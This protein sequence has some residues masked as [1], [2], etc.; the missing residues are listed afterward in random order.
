MTNVYSPSVDDPALDDPMEEIRRYETRFARPRS[1]ARATR[2]NAGKASVYGLPPLAQWNRERG[3]ALGYA[4]RMA[5][6][7][8]RDGDLQGI[9]PGLMPL[10]R[11]INA[12]HN[13]TEQLWDQLEPYLVPADEEMDEQPEDDD[14]DEYDVPIDAFDDTLVNADDIEPPTW[15]RI[16]GENSRWL[17]DKDVPA[18]LL[19][20]APAVNGCAWRAMAAAG[21]PQTY[22]RR[23][24]PAEWEGTTLGNM[25]AFLDSIRRGYQFFDALGRKVIEQR[26]DGKIHVRFAMWSN[27]VAAF[28]ARA[29]KPL[30]LIEEDSSPATRDAIKWLCEKLPYRGANSMEVAALWEGCGIRAPRFGGN[31]T[32][33]FGLDMVGSYPTILSDPRNVF[34]AAEGCEVIRET[35]MRCTAEELQDAVF[36]YLRA[37]EMPQE[38]R[39]L[40]ANGCSRY[41]FFWVWADAFKRIHADLEVEVAAYFEP[42]IQKM[43]APVSW[44]E[45]AARVNPAAFLVEAGEVKRRAEA[46]PPKQPITEMN[47]EAVAKLALKI[48][49]T[50]YSGFLQKESGERTLCTTTPM[51]EDEQHYHESAARTELDYTPIFGSTE[52]AAL[53]SRSKVYTKVGRPAMLACF[54]YLAAELVELLRELK[55]ADSSVR[56][57]GAVTDCL[58]VDAGRLTRT[59]VLQ[60]P[61]IKGG[62]FRIEAENVMKGVAPAPWSAGSCAAAGDAAE[63]SREEVPYFSRVMVTGPPGVGKSYFVENELLPSL[64]AEGY[65]V[66]RVTPTEDFAKATGCKTLQSL[67]K[68]S[69]CS[70]QVRALMR[71]T[72]LIV[73]E[74]GLA[75]PALLR[76]IQFADPARLYVVGDEAQLAQAGEFDTIAKRLDMQVYRMDYGKGADRFGGDRRMHQLLKW[77]RAAILGGRVHRWTPKMIQRMRDFGVQFVQEPTAGR[78]VLAWRNVRV[79]AYKEKG[80][81]A[82][83]IHSSQGRTIEGELSI[84]DWQGELRLL[85][86]AVSRARSLDAVELVEL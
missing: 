38:E 20:Y 83:T 78:K 66:L 73:D 58:L 39:D 6:T 72:V 79:D 50:Y 26:Y 41:G 31:R 76:Q 19:A 4:I 16:V 32:A 56:L 29:K 30:E 1:G 15:L 86:T 40:F 17:M 64:Q 81:D 82:Q 57:I 5:L 21:I 59:E 75:C 48:A 67:F 80:H 14:D 23:L 60:L 85:Y 11:Q 13:I 35:G 71:R 42:R 62:R 2:R 74:V 25:R 24:D 70:L 45:F 61:K 43:G 69:L 7:T 34:P 68:P 47:E 33:R 9:A 18:K 27:H 28:K 53:F 63:I 77:M 3:E 65:E 12:S 54:S 84:A 44:E 10:V 52:D 36:Y 51:G 46:N 37:P 55:A 49:L 8:R 22:L